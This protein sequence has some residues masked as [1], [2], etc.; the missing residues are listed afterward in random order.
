MIIPRLSAIIGLA[1]LV[2]S[3]LAAAPSAPRAAAT[4]A[5]GPQTIRP[6]E[7]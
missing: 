6:G 1:V 7:L 3:A 2:N 5:S 4:V